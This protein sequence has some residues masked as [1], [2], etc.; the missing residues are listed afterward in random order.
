MEETLAYR[1]RLKF[2]IFQQNIVDISN[3]NGAR[4]N[5]RHQLS[6]DENFKK[7]S[8]ISMIYWFGG[9]NLMKESSIE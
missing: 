6:I 7:I 9:E 5:I 2:H 1:Q 4:H 3:I 8:V